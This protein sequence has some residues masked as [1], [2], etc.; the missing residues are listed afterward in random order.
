MRILLA[1]ALLAGCASSGFARNQT[2][3]SLCNSPAAT[4]VDRDGGVTVENLILSGRWGSNQATVFLP[5]KEP[6]GGAV[7]FS[8]SRIHSDTGASVDLLPMAFTL[9]RAGAAVIVPRRT[10][11]WLPRD[12][13]TNREGGVV[14]CAEQW[15]VDHAKVFNHGEEAVNKNNIVVRVGYAYVGPSLC[16][17][18]GGSDCR[19]INPFISGRC[20]ADIPG[21][22]CRHYA[23]VF[24]GEGEHP[25]STLRILSDGGLKSA[26]WVQKELGL[27][28]ISALR[29]P[30]EP[31]GT[32]EVENR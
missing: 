27:A 4:T 21:K 24:L 11:I 19:Y 18:W 1:A 16:D 31:L 32:A 17:P 9:A 28:R 7:V 29:S 12:R 25:G 15:L 8:H 26:Q 2:D 30:K 20:D 10:L 6:A 13:S 3:E 5:R 14:V 22:Y 23:R